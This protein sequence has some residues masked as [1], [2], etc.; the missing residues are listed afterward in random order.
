MIGKDFLLV[1]YSEADEI[2]NFPL[3]KKFQSARISKKLVVYHAKMV[4]SLKQF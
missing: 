1:Q 3:E 2:F 4:S